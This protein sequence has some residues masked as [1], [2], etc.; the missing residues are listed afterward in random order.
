MKISRFILEVIGSLVFFCL[1]FLMVCYLYFVV[2]SFI[3][4]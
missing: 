3:P 1:F 2:F 4:E